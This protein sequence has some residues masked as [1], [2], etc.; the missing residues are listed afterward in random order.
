MPIEIQI[1]RL[2]WSME[3]GIFSG[4]LKKDG[5]L[6]KSGE[7]LFILEGEKAAQDIESTDTGKL[8]IPKD[9]PQSGDTVKVGQVIGFLIAE[10]E[11]IDSTNAPPAAPEAPLYAASA[12]NPEGVSATDGSPFPDVNATHRLQRQPISPRARR[13]AE[14]LNV[15]ISTLTSSGKAGRITEADVLKAV[16]GEPKTATPKTEALTGIATAVST[17]RRTIAERTAKSF[18]QIPH[19]YLR[20]EA[21]VTNSLLCANI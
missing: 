16:D 4:W 2:G 9:S 8:Q 6:V 5:D 17:I 3:E 11:N 13:L 12:T 18:S 14:Q 1:P 15:D 10:N 20:A 7:P 21:D 19:F